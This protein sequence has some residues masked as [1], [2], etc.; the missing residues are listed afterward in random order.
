MATPTVDVYKLEKLRALVFVSDVPASQSLNANSTFSQLI[1]EIG[2]IEQFSS[3][4]H[5]LG[6]YHNVGISA[7]YSHPSLDI[8]TIKETVFSALAAVINRHTI[9]SA[10][11]IDEHSAHP[12][13][14]RLP[15]INLEEAVTFLARNTPVPENEA[16]TELDRLLQD[17]HNIPFKS[18][19]GELPFWRL[20]ILIKPQT[21]TGSACEFI[22]SFIFHH[23]LGD[24]GSGM[25]FHKHFLSALLSNAAPLTSTTIPSP[26]LPLTPNLELL[27]PTRIPASPPTPSLQGLWS[28]THTSLPLTSKFRSLTIPS[29]TTSRFLAACRANSTTITA[30][31]PVLIASALSS[32]LPGQYTDFEAC[33]P[34]N[35]RR[36]L[37]VTITATEP[38]GVFIDAFSH[39]YT[40][41]DLSPSSLWGEAR[42]S[43]EIITSYLQT[44]NVHINIAKLGK[45]ADMRE[46]FLSRVGQE[47]GSSFDI[48]NLGGLGLTSNETDRGE[49]GWKMG[50]MAFSRSAFV[51]GSAFSTGLVTGPDGCLVFGF[52]W[53][54]GV[55][56]RELIENVAGH[57]ERDIERI[58][59]T[60]ML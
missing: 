1:L 34:V 42:R 2:A 10:I 27:H 16:D 40:R 8:L 43:K 54:E 33:I 36:F 38:M 46:F 14:A 39:Y 20:I 13:F 30:T 28:G 49:E 15:S 45:V 6:F 47:R 12:Y 9:L 32:L 55:V 31:I 50:R 58:A 24:G 21:R 56:E 23:A 29:S 57:V 3:A 11:P 5:H 7:S 53:Q 51:A 41:E 18:R 52:V 26:S 60:E 17:Q 44:A 22:G 19:Y 48:S 37:P 35:L 25:L 4:R 59:R